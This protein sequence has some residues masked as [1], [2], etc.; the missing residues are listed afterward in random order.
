VAAEATWT[1]PPEGEATADGVAVGPTGATP[2]AMAIGSTERTS[3]AGELAVAEAGEG[4]SRQGPTRDVVTTGACR[5]GEAAG[6]TADA[7]GSSK[8]VAPGSRRVIKVLIGTSTSSGTS[9]DE[10]FWHGGSSPLETST[11]A[12]YKRREQY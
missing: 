6:T 9:E 8:I 4:P 11:T 1:A 2:D 5:P 3:C 10:P 12:G 7:E